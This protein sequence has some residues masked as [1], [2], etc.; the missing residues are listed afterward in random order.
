MSKEKL[1]DAQ[2]ET[3]IKRLNNSPY[4]KLAQKEVRLKYKRRLHL[5]NLRSLEK[6]GR[7]LAKEGATLESLEELIAEIEEDTAALE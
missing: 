1:T 2:V 3:E 4:V 6:R 5:Y 7:Q